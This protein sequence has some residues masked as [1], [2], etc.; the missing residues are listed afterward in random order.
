MVTKIVLT[1]L[2]ILAAY[3]Y[4]KRRNVVAQS[5][6]KSVDITPAPDTPFRLIA[7]VLIL[8]SLA[9]TLGYVVYHWIDGHQTLQV[10][11]IS[12][13]AEKPQLY[14][15]Y[16]SELNE[17]SFTTVQGQIIRIGSQDRLQI[18]ALSD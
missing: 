12:P 15:V 18:E 14:Q 2:V 16:K 9:G 17:R 4:L 10:T 5:R 8:V 3:L 11:L 6:V 13:G 1:L 7:I